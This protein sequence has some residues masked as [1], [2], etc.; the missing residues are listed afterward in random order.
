MLVTVTLGEATAPKQYDNQGFLITSSA[1]L[2]PRS[3]PTAILENAAT[4]PVAQAQSSPTTTSAV[5]TK[6]VT[7]TSGAAAIFEIYDTMLAIA[8][9]LVAGM[10][11][12]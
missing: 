6:I 8:S 3:S 11:L 1:S 2:A 5:V 4:A 10:L 7:K 9:C 12:L